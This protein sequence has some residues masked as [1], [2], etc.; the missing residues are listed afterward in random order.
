M[1]LTKDLFLREIKGCFCSAGS[2]YVKYG[3]KHTIKNNCYWSN[4]QLK[5][6][7]EENGIQNNIEVLDYKKENLEYRYYACNGNHRLRI[8]KDIAIEN[9]KKLD[10]EKITVEL[11]E[12]KEK[13]KNVLTLVKKH[14]R[15]FN[16][17]TR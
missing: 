16:T 11:V 3:V 2:F 14:E 6:D 13:Y 1:S 15:R 4:R 10:E 5:K 7:I 17:H 9:D 8:L 12:D